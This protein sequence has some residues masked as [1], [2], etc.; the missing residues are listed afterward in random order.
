MYLAVPTQISCARAWIA[1]A[2]DL[3]DHYDE[4]YNVVVDVEDAS[5]HDDTDNRVI[6]LVDR[7]LRDHAQNPIITVANTIFPKALHHAHGSPSF[8]NVYLRDYDRLTATKRWGRYFE[9]MTR[10]QKADGGTYNPLQSLIDKLRRQETAGIRYTSAYELAIYDPLKDGRLLYGGQ[11]LSF[12]SFKLHRERG[13]M[14]TALYRNHAYITRCLGNL[15]GLG[16]LQAF[17]ASEVGVPSGSLTCLSTHAEL[18]TGKGWGK[19][20]A[21]RLVRTAAA[22]LPQQTASTQAQAC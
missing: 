19:E 17:V 6:T 2:S 10:H 15:I 20:D 22:L 7:F 9:R 14:V 13:L 11:C 4:S 21:R 12:I 3:I 8:Y 16:R 18:D 1:A 5:T